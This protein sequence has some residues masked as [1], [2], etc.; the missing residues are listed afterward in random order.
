MQDV[1]NIALSRKHGRRKISDVEYLVVHRTIGA[2]VEDSI[3]EF[4][5]VEQFAAGFYTGGLYPYHFFVQPGQVYQCL[6]LTVN[7]PAALSTLNRRG[8]HIALLGDF[9]K[10]AP[11]SLHIM[12]LKQ[13]LTT[14]TNCFNGKTQIIGHTEQSTASKD[15]NKICP[16][17]LLDLNDVR[18]YVSLNQSNLCELSPE[19][20]LKRAGFVV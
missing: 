17:K 20:G 9:R 5:N 13:L 4:R 19:A 14:L 12:Q 7:A 8:I 11:I 6:P 1:V 16:G 2:S 18:S 3:A 15:P 10:T